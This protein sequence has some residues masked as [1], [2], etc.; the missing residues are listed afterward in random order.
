MYSETHKPSI[1]PVMARYDFPFYASPHVV[2]VR[3]FSEKE[4]R[5]GSRCVITMCEDQTKVLDPAYFDT[6]EDAA[7]NPADRSMW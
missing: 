7:E 1:N 6:E 4:K 2:K 3:P 5:S